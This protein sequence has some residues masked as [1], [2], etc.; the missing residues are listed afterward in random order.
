MKLAQNAHTFTECIV[1]LTIY[2][3]S[4]RP[5]KQRELIENYPLRDPR[6]TAL[7]SREKCRPLGNREMRLRSAG[8]TD[9]CVCKW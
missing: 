5:E 1:L 4:H 2:W 6:P 7:D 8:G 3:G 9:M